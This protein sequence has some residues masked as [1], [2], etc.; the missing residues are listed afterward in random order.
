MKFIKLIFEGRE[1]DFKATYVNKFSPE[2]LDAIINMVNEVPNGSKFLTFLGRV[3]PNTIS[4][5]LIDETVKPVLKKFVAIG[6]NLEIKDINQYKT[7]AELNTAIQKYENR[8][9]RSVET[10]EG[11]DLVYEDDTFTVIAPL[12]TKASCYYGAGTKWCTSSSA[13]NTHFNNYMKDGKLFYILDK[14]KPTS[15]RFYK[16]ALLKKFEGDESYF[17]APDEKFTN[18]WIMGTNKLARIKEQ[19]DS[20]IKEKY[21]K[22]LEIWGD[23]EKAAIERKRLARVE[24]QRIENDLIDEANERRDN[25]EWSMDNLS[26]GDTG[27]CAH[28]LFNFLISEGT[29]EEKTP[30]DKSEIARIQNEIDRLQAEY[31]N[32][33][34]VRGDLLDEISELEDELTELNNKIDVYDILPIGDY[35][36]KEFTTTE[37]QGRWK[38][39]DSDDTER[40]AVRYVKDLIDDTGYDGFN[41]S[42]IMEHF[43]DDSFRMYL[44]EFFEEDVYN[45]PEIYLDDSD[46]ELSRSQEARI[47]ELKE[48]ITNLE[49]EKESLDDEDE[50][51][52]SEYERLNDEITILQEEIQEI[53]DDP[54]GEYDSDKLDSIVSERISEYGYDA[55]DFYENYLG[56][57][58]FTQWCVDNGFIDDDEFAQAVVDTDGY[59]TVLN[60]YDGSEE[61]IRFEGETYY[62]FYDG[63][64]H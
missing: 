12:T 20:Y 49:S 42:F 45:N 15:D 22:E 11:A 61:S 46:K 30:E 32:D 53:E 31:D 51:Y 39:G 57:N 29:I 21:A 25:D 38:V 55:K 19:I 48:T 27:S 6:P 35:V 26:E 28:A 50:D 1:D 16:V 9:R 13:D 43:D 23:K 54:D 63:D 34:E 5:G 18:G 64:F 8:I 44:R 33:E 58:D 40:E 7:F 24:Q 59:G 56:G 52:E 3:L 41:Q 4:Q 60:N 36:L 37:F 14:T 62:I 10:I 47:F 2:K 17:D